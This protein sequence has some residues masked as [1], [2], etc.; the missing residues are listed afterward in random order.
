MGHD[1][2]LDEPQGKRGRRRHPCPVVA[3]SPNGSQPQMKPEDKTQMRARVRNR[4]IQAFAVVVVALLA[5]STAFACTTFKGYLEATGNGTGNTAQRVA[6]TGSGMNWCVVKTP[7]VK[8]AAGAGAGSLTLATGPSNTIAASSGGD[9]CATSTQL[10]PSGRLVQYSTAVTDG[11]GYMP[12]GGGSGAVHN[13]HGTDGTVLETNGTV[14]SNGVW[15]SGTTG[16]NTINFTAVPGPQSVCI[17]G[18]G[19]LG[20]ADA[21]AI[22]FDAV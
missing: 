14:D 4:V 16:T 22:N 2:H 21:I 6:G 18:T 11:A 13:C 8:V 17:Y 20:S 1:R 9:G 19:K 12:Q 15:K 3:A 5:S 7:T 10:G